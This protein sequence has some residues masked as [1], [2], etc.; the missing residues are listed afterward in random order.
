MRRV[1]DV[2]KGWSKSTRLCTAVLMET[3]DLESGNASCKGIYG[4]I[5]IYMQSESWN[6]S[7]ASLACDEG[8]DIPVRIIFVLW[9]VSHLP[10]S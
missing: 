8:Q 1:L 6:N 2:A 7:K 5:C 9:R 10:Q 3:I 4:Y